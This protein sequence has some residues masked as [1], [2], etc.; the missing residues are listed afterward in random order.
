MDHIHTFLE[1]CSSFLFLAGL[2]LIGG[3]L[4]FLTCNLLL[5]SSFLC[6]LMLF[7]GLGFTFT[8]RGLGMALA[9]GEKE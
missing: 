5:G 7:F 2:V 8:G 6:M 9:G 3:S 4:A 1:Y